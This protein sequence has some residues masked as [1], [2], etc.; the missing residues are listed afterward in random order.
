MRESTSPAI[1]RLSGL[2]AA[3]TRTM[4][5]LAQSEAVRATTERL[6]NEALSGLERPASLASIESMVRQRLDEALAGQADPVARALDR[7]RVERYGGDRN[8]AQDR[9]TEQIAA[10]SAKQQW[11]LAAL[12][13]VVTP[14]IMLSAA[15]PAGAEPRARL[16]RS[17][18]AI[19]AVVLLAIALALPMIEVEARLVELRIQ[20]SGAWLEF[21]D[22]V[23][24]FSSKSVWTIAFG[25]AALGNAGSAAIALLI[26]AL[27]AGLPIAKFSTL[28]LTTLRGR[29]PRSGI[30]HWLVT[31]SG[32]WS[33]ADV[34]VIAILMAFIGFNGLADH[35]LARIG[36]L[37]P[38]SETENATRL[39]VGLYLFVAHV[40]LGMALGRRQ[41]HPG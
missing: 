37:A 12:A 6:T 15:G 21:R 30:T 22:Q 35:Q 13:L 38:G 39:G 24:F 36:L 11:L 1:W 33:M 8:I 40:L 9:L 19:A 18:T 23:L 25:L 32:K 17:V 20:L 28:A 41:D 7:E 4:Q 2:E 10:G 34:F 31:S 5:S 16:A 14:L 3:I 29:P 27:C 26:V